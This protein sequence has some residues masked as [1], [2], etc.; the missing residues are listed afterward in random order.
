MVWLYVLLPLVAAA[1]AFL[2]RRLVTSNR[3]KRLTDAWVCLAAGACFFVIW[4]LEAEHSLF[5]L[6]IGISCLVAGLVV[7]LFYSRQATGAG[8]QS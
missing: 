5:T 2:L 8:G 4:L 3:A 1:G 6:A 7:L